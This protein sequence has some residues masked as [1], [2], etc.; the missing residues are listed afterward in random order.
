MNFSE[1]PGADSYLQYTHTNTQNTPHTFV[2][3]CG[4][5]QVSKEKNIKT[6]IAYYLIAF[7]WGSFTN[8]NINSF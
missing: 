2:D 8:G 5:I 1:F 4:C 3:R 6:N 7:K